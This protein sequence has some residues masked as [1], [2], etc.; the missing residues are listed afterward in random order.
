MYLIAEHRINC[1]IRFCKKILEQGTH[2]QLVL[3]LSVW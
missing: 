3:I 2:P 1:I